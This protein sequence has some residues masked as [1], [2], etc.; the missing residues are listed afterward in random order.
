MTSELVQSPLFGLAL[1][2]ATFCLMERLLRNVR[3]P[4][5]NPLI[6]TIVLIILF[7]KLT[8][9]SYDDY[10]IGA[11]FLTMMITPATVAL[12]LPLYRNL[13]KLKENILPVLAATVVGIVT[14]CTLSILI[15]H[16]FSLKDSMILSLL[17]KSVT[18]A[19]SLDISKQMGG[20]SAVTLAIVVSTGI[21][22][23]LIGSQ[24]FKIFK[25]NSPVARGIALGSTSHAIGTGRAIELGEVEG[26]LSGLCICVNGIVTVLLL[27]VFYRFVEAML[28]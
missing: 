27:P 12:A 16:L 15:G 19:I 26:I 5:V 11:N 10:N 21:L 8:G 14:N 25:I 28:Y 22:G 4:F 13:D 20:L 18:T 24:V 9:V 17:P 3:I 7:L 1:T 23:A 6:V 2:V